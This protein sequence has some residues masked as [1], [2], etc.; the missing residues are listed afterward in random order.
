MWNCIIFK[1]TYYL[2]K[3]LDDS[4]MCSGVESLVAVSPVGPAGDHTHAQQSKELDDGKPQDD[5]QGI[6][7]SIMDQ[8][9]HFHLTALSVEQLWLVQFASAQGAGGVFTAALGNGAVVGEPSGV[10]PAGVVLQ[11]TALQLRLEDIHGLGVWTLPIVTPKNMT[12]GTFQA[13]VDP[14]A[15]NKGAHQGCNFSRKDDHDD[16]EEAAKATFRLPEGGAASHDANDEHDDAD[17]DDDDGRDEGVA[18]L[19]ETAKAVI[20]SDYVGSNIRQKASSS[21]EDEAEEEEHG[22][23]GD[24]AAVHVVSGGG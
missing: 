17:A 7:Q 11:S 23:G 20:C 2:Q 24:N 13:L 9:L 16:K 18:V 5:Q 6:A 3:R 4:R 10:S 14:A 22:F 8:F 15:E 21:P 19:D 1:F 12:H